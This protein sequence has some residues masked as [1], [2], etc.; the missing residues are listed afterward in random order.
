MKNLRNFRM[1]IEI[2]KIWNIQQKNG[3]CK[4]F[5]EFKKCKEFAK[6]LSKY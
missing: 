4:K 6:C 1:I 2:R 5:V 3:N